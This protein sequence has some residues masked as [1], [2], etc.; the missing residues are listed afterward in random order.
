MVSVPELNTENS[1]IS[2]DPNPFSDNATINIGREFYN[3]T[4]LIFDILGN[5]VR[6]YFISERNAIELNRLNL[7]SGIY[8]IQLT[9]SK[10]NTVSEKIVIE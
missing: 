10:G 4:V 8:S 6:K 3:S 2:I 9:N 1:K 5:I 7:K